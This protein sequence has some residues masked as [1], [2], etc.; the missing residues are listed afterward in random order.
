MS[1]I[2]TLT[3]ETLERLRELLANMEDGPEARDKLIVEAVNALPLLLSAAQPKGGDVAYDDNAILR[4]EIE[5]MAKNLKAVRA[6]ADKEEAR[7]RAQ[8]SGEP[9]EEALERAAEAFITK[10]QI[11]ED[12]GQSHDSTLSPEAEAIRAAF[13]TLQ[14]KRGDAPWPAQPSQRERDLSW[15]HDELSNRLTVFPRDLDEGDDEEVEITVTRGELKR[16]IAATAYRTNG[17]ERG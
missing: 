3:P 15:V 9:D 12:L 1:D 17:G 8:L 6:A 5:A 2:D 4:A 11:I 16:M 14:P 7:L 13:S 10:M